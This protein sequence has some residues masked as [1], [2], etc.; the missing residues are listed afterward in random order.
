MLKAHKFRA[1]PRLAVAAA[2]AA[3]G[4]V[5]AG[6]DVA[7]Q[8][9]R[10]GGRAAPPDKTIVFDIDVTSSVKNTF[11]ASAQDAFADAI[12]RLARQPHGAIQI[13]VRKI[14]HNPG[15]DQAALGTYHIDPVR[16][17]GDGNPFDHDCRDAQTATAATA[18][19][20]ARTIAREIR[21]IHVPTGHAGTRIR[22][23][24]AIAGDLLARGRGEKRLVIA[25][26]MR[27]SN[28]IATKPPVINLNDVHVV[29]LF[30]CNQGIALCQQRR[31]AWR[32]EV[33]HDGAVHPVTFLFSQQMHDL[34]R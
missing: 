1:R 8:P 11:R 5:A 7:G 10:A 17:C 24:L 33:E 2:V 14:D 9:A 32:S 22:G 34:W 15:G 29:V 28:A 19:E 30:A 20:E 31:N 6:C 25:S 26:D 16:A 4:M 3:L 21:T 18:V 27:P 23:A 13:Y 12:V